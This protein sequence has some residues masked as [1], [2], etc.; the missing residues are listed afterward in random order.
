MN[1]EIKTKAKFYLKQYAENLSDRI[2][3]IN[4]CIRTEENSLA[5]VPK[6]SDP[7]STAKREYQQEYYGNRLQLWKERLKKRTGTLK[8]IDEIVTKL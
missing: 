1:E 8:E 6:G 7:E 3:S 4:E 5:G 2:I